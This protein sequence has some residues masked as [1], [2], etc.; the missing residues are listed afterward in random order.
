MFLENLPKKVSFSSQK[1]GKS[2]AYL[3]NHN[4]QYWLAYLEKTYQNNE[5]GSLRKFGIFRKENRQ[6]CLRNSIDA[7]V[8]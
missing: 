7:Q 4:Q 3:L 5:S 8:W 6:C 2:G 1:R